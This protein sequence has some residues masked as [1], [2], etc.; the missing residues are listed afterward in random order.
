MSRGKI[1]GPSLTLPLQ[2]IL[3]GPFADAGAAGAAAHGLIWWDI[4]GNQAHQGQPKKMNLVKR[5]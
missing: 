1:L 4:C 3:Q 2:N 5:V